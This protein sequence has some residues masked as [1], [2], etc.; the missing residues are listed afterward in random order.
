MINDNRIKPWSWKEISKNS[1]IT[2]KMIHDNL[3]L[4]WSWMHVGANKNLTFEM[5]K[6]HANQKWVWSCIGNNISIDIIDG[7]PN[8]H[9]DWSTIS[10]NCFLKNQNAQ[11]F[12]KF[13]QNKIIEKELIEKVLH[14]T[15]IAYFINKYNYNIGTDELFYLK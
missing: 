6:L 5:V 14:P 8:L 1:A 12:E 10:W 15:R 13:E 4:P 3:N 11:I 7:N 9:W 2:M